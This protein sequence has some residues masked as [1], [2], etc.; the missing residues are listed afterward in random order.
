MCCH[1]GCHSRKRSQ[2][3]DES[4]HDKTFA[5]SERSRPPWIN[6]VF[7]QFRRLFN[8][9]GTVLPLTLSAKHFLSVWQP[10]KTVTQSCCVKEKLQACKKQSH[11][12]TPS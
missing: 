3:A 1:S 11:P 8:V 7:D 10:S 12:A 2:D 4:S 5:M 6:L 9:H